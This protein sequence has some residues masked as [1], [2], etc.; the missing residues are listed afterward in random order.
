MTFSFRE[1]PSRLLVI[2]SILFLTACEKSQQPPQAGGFPTPMVSVA[3]VVTKTVTPW[4]QINGQIVAKEVVEIQPRVGGVIEKVSFTEGDT[5]KKGDLLYLLDQ[6]PFKTELSGAKANLTR[7]QAQASLAASEV[8]RAKDLV[9]RNLLSPEKFDQLLATENQAHAN[10]ES[11]KASVKL[12][13]LNLTYTKIRSPIDGQTGRT[14]ISQG[15]LVASTP[16][17][18]HLTTIFS[19]DPI[20]VMFGVDEMNYLK[21][22]KA[23][24]NFTQ[25]KNKDKKQIIHFGLS[26]GKDYPYK[27]YIDFIS[28][29]VNP[30]TGTV[31]IRAVVDNKD[32]DLIPGL[33][34]RVKVPVS[35]P[36]EALLISD[37][38]IL[39]DQDR[40][41][42]Y[43]LN[44][45]NQALRRDVKI[46]G[47]FEGL[48]AITEG[49]NGGEQIVVHGIQKVFFPGM[50]VKP[51]VIA[52]GEMPLAAAPKPP[53]AEH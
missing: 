15:N 44:E 52:M 40:R 12:A 22:I 25:K 4:T 8:T 53:S 28:N 36:T 14:L 42:V 16:T 18:D 6:Q 34:A 21:H 17:P 10:V 35:A 41:Y 30:E 38:A 23:I 32:R 20:Y 19:L 33:F 50:E 13:E 46:G 29:Q 27:G 7:A 31:L 43:V 49:L 5:V 47:Q 3:E 26:H 45:K 39:T 9:K 51:Q 2:F 48:R 11:A 1:N 24:K 37:Q